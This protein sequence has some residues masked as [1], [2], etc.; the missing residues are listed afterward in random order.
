MNHIKLLYLE[1]SKLFVLSGFVKRY[2]IDWVSGTCLSTIQSIWFLDIVF[3]Q[4]K[5]VQVRIS[6]NA[7][8]CGAL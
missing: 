4:F 7:R 2:I 3:R 1:T 5:V 8:R 6:M